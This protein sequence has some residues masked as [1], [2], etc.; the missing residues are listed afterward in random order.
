MATVKNTLRALMDREGQNLLA[1]MDAYGKES[2]EY[3]IALEIFQRGRAQLL[4]K[5]KAPWASAR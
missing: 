2:A 1:V 3:A 4:Q 5:A